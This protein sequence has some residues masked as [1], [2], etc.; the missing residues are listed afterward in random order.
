MQT[1]YA[2]VGGQQTAKICGLKEFV[3]FAELLQMLQFADLRFVYPIFRDL[4]KSNFF[5]SSNTYFS[6]LQ[7]LQIML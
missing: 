6:S 4:R 3:R 7:I 1:K 5:K 2:N